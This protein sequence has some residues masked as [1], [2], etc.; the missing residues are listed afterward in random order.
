M[1]DVWPDRVTDSNSEIAFEELV[2]IRTKANGILLRK[3]Q[4]TALKFIRKSD[5]TPCIQHTDH[6]R[7][8]K[9]IEN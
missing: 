6:I 8:D 7:S 9:R 1:E 2:D 4:I 5:K 3:H